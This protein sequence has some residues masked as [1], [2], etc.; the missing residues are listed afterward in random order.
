MREILQNN[1]YKIFIY[2]E[3][4]KDKERLKNHSRLKKTKGTSKVNEAHFLDWIQK[5][6]KKKN[7]SV[8]IR[9]TG[10]ITW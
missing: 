1:W 5:Q 7:I 2:I 3:V 4:M 6:K 10:K 8:H 9:I